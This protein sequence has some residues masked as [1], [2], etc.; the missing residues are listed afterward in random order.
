MSPTGH[1]YTTKPG[2]SIFFPLLVA[3]T[4]E[5]VLPTSSRAQGEHRGLMMPARRQ[6]RAAERAARIASERRINEAVIAAQSGRRRIAARN[7]PPPF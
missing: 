7:D 5:L 2:A 4:G 6:T 3:S 1:I